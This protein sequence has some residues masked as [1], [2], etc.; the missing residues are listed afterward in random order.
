MTS[1]AATIQSQALEDYVCE[2]FDLDLQAG[3]LS[4]ILNDPK[5]RNAFNRARSLA[6][7]RLFLHLHRDP[8]PTLRGEDVHI[9]ALRSHCRGIFAS[10]GDLGEIA[11]DP[12]RALVTM[13][14]MNQS[15]QLLKTIPCDS[16][17]CVWASNW[18]RGRACA[19]V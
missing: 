17:T 15:M 10:G 18:R 5:T 11:K 2:G 1:N 14:Q 3:V 6:L 19:W 16:C 12:D 9:V 8:Y 13:E 4:V 7:Q